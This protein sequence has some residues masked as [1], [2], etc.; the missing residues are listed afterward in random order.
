MLEIAVPLWW[1]SLEL[2]GSFDTIQKSGLIETIGTLLSEKGDLLFYQSKKKG[3]TAEV[4]NVLAKGMAFA[5]VAPG[6]FDLFNFHWENG[7]ASRIDPGKPSKLPP[8]WLQNHL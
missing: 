2:P 1:I 3:E 7:K 4:F 8:D 6:G 5:S